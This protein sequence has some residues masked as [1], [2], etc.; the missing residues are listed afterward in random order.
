MAVAMRTGAP[1]LRGRVGEAEWRM[2]V[3]LAAFYRLVAH[4]DM[5]DR[6]ATHISAAVPDEPGAFLINPH[7]MLFHEV[8]ASAL[9]KIDLDGNVLLDTGWPVNRAGF[10]IHSAVHAARHD[11]ACVAHTHTRAGMAVS[12]MACGLLPINQ[13][14]LRFYDRIGYHDYEGLAVDTAERARLVRDLGPHKAMILR[15]H[16]L[17]AAGATVAEAFSVLVYLERCCQAQVDVMAARTELVT[18]PA[19]VCERTARQYEAELVPERDWT[20]HLRLLDGLDAG[21]AS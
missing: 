8:T 15:N 10:V 14:A 20:A 5:A 21:Y 12:A 1:S 13:H 16:G 4:Y 19:E 7:G 17:L 9:V 18:P 11:V 6:T 2:R 3:D